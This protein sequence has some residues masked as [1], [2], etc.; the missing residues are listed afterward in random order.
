MWDREG[1]KGDRERKNKERQR[2]IE[3]WRKR[4]R[5]KWRHGERETEKETKRD[6]EKE[7][8]RE[9]ETNIILERVDRGKIALDWAE[10][11][12]FWPRLWL[13][14]SPFLFPPKKRE[15]EKE[16]EWAQI[17]IKGHAFLLDHSNEHVLNKY[18][19]LTQAYYWLTPLS[20]VSCP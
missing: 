10:R 2:K 15:E 9:R 18:F 7:E 19:E 17:V 20:G 5:E 14:F 12:D 4:D 6:K 1:G 8:K 11:H 3:T 13:F 16:N